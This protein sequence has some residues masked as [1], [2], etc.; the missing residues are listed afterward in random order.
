MDRNSGAI[1]ELKQNFE[2]KDLPED[3]EQNISVRYWKIFRR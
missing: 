2:E 1:K 3:L